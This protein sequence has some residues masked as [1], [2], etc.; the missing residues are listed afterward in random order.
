MGVAGCGKSTV[1]RM[2]AAELGVPYAE[3]DDHHPPANVAK[4]ARGIPLDDTDREPWLAA[5]ADRVALSGVDGGLVV[6]CSALK[7][8][9]RDVLR[10]AD[11]RTWF[12]HLVVDH[13]TALQRVANRTAH[14]MPASLVTTQ[15]QA[16]E[17]LGSDEN[18]VPVDATGIPRDTTTAVMA[19]DLFT[20]RFTRAGLREAARGPSRRLTMPRTCPGSTHV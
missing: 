13:A 14:F 3:A 17:T 16:L 5:I 8:R 10:G 19:S 6:S 20:G 4:M 11:P 2:L 18:G 7:R 12:V 1:G 9:Y 15:F